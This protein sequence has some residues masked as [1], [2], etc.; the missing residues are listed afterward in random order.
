MYLGL[1]AVIAKSFARIHH[2]NLVNFGILPLTF[3]NEADY[4]QISQDDVLVIRNLHQQLQ[5]E[6]IEVENVTKGVTFA[7]RHGLTP[8]Q[9]VSLPPA[10]SIIRKSKTPQRKIRKSKLADFL[11]I[12]LDHIF[13][14]G[15]V[16]YCK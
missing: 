5:Q 9:V 16:L 6:T 13:L 15:A 8:R 7:V 3:V 10:V 14:A 12:D 11:F 4:D 2:A 1:K